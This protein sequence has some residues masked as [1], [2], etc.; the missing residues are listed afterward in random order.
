MKVAKKFKWE[1]A[2]RIPWHKGKCQHLHGHSYKMYV[3]FDGEL[4]EQGI[5]I[6]FND[7]K[8]IINPYIELFDHATIVSKHDI[9]L[10]KVFIENEWKHYILPFDS[11]AENLCN[12]FAEMI[13]ENHINLLKINNINSISVTVYETETAYAKIEKNIL[14]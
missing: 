3:E 5:V 13:I 2:H 6:D 7:I 14:L 1:A 9:E 12:F 10:Q 4:N 8:N 11:T